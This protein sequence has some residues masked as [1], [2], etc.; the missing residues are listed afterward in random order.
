[1]RLKNRNSEIIGMRR[2]TMLLACAVL[3][4]ATCAS[5]VAL[6]M[7]VDAAAAPDAKSN[8]KFVH[9]SAGVM[10]GNVVTK[11]MPKYPPEAK[12]KRIQGRVTLNATI[13][14]QGDITDLTVASGPEALRRSALDAVKQWKYKPFLLNGRPV[15]VKTTINVIYSLQM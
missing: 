1:M 12:K 7:N 14:E 2:I 10:A 5:A 13:S 11:V 6:H 15:A 3:A 4:G 9:V 8:P